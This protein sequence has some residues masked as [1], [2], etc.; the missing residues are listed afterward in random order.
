MRIVLVLCSALL[1]LAG[2]TRESSS[3]SQGFRPGTAQAEVLQQLTKMNG[4]ILSQTTN[5]V[6]AEVTVPEING[7]VRVHLTFDQGVLDRVYFLP[8]AR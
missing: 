4:K 3:E 1:L 5:G 2:C 8:Q 7:P 6:L